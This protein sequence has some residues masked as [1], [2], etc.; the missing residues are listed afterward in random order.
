MHN[1]VCD[2]FNLQNHGLWLL[3]RCCAAVSLQTRY[4]RS[5]HVAMHVMSHALKQLLYISSLKLLSFCQQ[6]LCRLR[7]ARV[8]NG[9]TSLPRCG[10]PPN[11]PPSLGIHDAVNKVQA[12]I[13]VTTAI[14]GLPLNIYL[15]VIIIRFKLLHQQS[16]F[17]CLQIIAVEVLYHMVVPI[18]IMTSGITG[19]WIFGEV[20]CNI[21]GMI[22]DLFAIFRFSMTFVI[23]IDRFIC[24]FGPYFYAR[25]GG[26]LAWFLSGS[27]WVISLVRIIV[28][29]YGI[30][31]CYYYIPTFKTCTIYSGCSEECEY[32]AAVSISFIVLSGVVLPLSLY[33]MIFI[34][35]KNITKGHTIGYNNST[36]LRTNIQY[37]FVKKLQRN[38]TLVTAFLLLISIVGGTT[39]A[40]TMY[41]VAIFYREPNAVLFIVNMIIGRT[42]FNLIPVFDAIAFTRHTD[43][44]KISASL[45]KS[46]S[47]ICNNNNNYM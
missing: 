14:I 8:M 39:P 27:M 45:L 20:F 17:L 9:N 10:L 29:L 21:N 1:Y 7:F 28:P 38:K 35:V 30:L 36:N 47:N 34:K 37:A 18:T 46:L 24:I 31:D 32:F 26:K 41:I 22:H 40:F 12:V 33:V 25:H 42:F 19:V 3:L 43:I 44:R 23:T 6:L 16:L 4:L 15:L 11:F 13:A 2:V 5:T